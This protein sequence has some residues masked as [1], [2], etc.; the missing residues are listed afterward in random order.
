MGVGGGDIG[1]NL[2]LDKA[3]RRSYLPGLVRR[4]LR[5]QG[6]HFLANLTLTKLQM[7]K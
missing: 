6:R 5:S 2:S 1:D 3:T 4:V 7:T